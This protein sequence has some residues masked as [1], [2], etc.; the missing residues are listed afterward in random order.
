MKGLFRILLLTML[1]FV[2]TNFAGA[3]VK[4]GILAQ[5]GP[6]IA[7]KEWAPLGDYLSKE[8]GEPVKI[9]PVKF[10]D[11]RDWYW[12]EP[13]SYI[14]ANSWYYVRAKVGKHARALV[15]VKYKGQGTLFGGVIFVRR[16]S[17]ITSLGDLKQKVLMCPKLTSLGGWLF[18]KGVLVHH[19]LIPEKDFKQILES[20]DESHDAVVYSVRDKKADVG[21]VR[22]NL[23]EAMQR[24]G[25]IN[26]SEFAVLNPQ[27]HEGFEV[28]CSTPLYPDWP[29]AAMGEASPEQMEKLKKTLL[30]IPANHPVLEQARG[31]ERFIEP[32]DYSPVEDLCKFLKVP[33]YNK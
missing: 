6:E 17:G 5:R 15:T 1:L 25:K 7:L 9:V 8:M 29:L 26:L 28:L 27:K 33:P 12:T 3:E 2:C 20:P 13:Q 31:I 24:E 18:Q 11:F 32:L 4:L 30:A 14:F 21:T 19:G 16:D 23:L 22:T 10:S